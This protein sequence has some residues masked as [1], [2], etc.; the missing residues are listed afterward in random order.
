V[1]EPTAEQPQ[2]TATVSPAT[3]QHS[4]WGAI[5]R[6]LGR[7][8]TSTVVLSV[9]FLATGAL[10]INIRPEAETPPADPAVV[11]QSVVPV[12][13]VPTEPS[14]TPTPTPEPVPTTTPERSS[15][16]EAPTTAS[17]DVPTSTDT[18]TGFP[19]TTPEPSEPSATLP[20]TPSTPTG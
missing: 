20:G 10:W 18:S 4:R 11:E 5:P 7:A 2:V 16:S 6:H 17:T 9:L 13:P 8:R 19:T 1:S 12:V 15:T 3:P 14:P